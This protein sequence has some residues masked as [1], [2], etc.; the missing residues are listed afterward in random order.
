MDNWAGFVQTKK[1]N[2][3]KSIVRKKK[4]Q[5]IISTGLPLLNYFGSGFFMLFSGM[6]L[7]RMQASA[8][9]ERQ[10]KAIL[11]PSGDQ[12]TD[13]IMPFDINSVFIS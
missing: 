9:P 2:T 12:S 11:V 3:Y 6:G 5:A 1:A 7:W 4:G 8:R 13:L 10:V